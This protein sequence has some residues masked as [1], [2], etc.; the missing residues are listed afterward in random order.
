M[1]SPLVVPRQPRNVLLTNPYC[2]PLREMYDRMK[3]ARATSRNQVEQDFLETMPSFD[4]GLPVGLDPG[5]AGKVQS[6]HLSGAIQNGKGDWFNNVIALLLERCAGMVKE[7]A[8]KSIDLKGEAARRLAIFG[9]APTAGGSGG[10]DLS[11]WLHA[12]RP[13][14]Y[15]FMG[16]RVLGDTDFAAVVRWAETAAQVVDAVGLY[17]YEPLP[18]SYAEYRRRWGVPTVYEL[19]RVLFRACTELRGL[20]DAPPEPIPVD[21]P[22]SPA[23]EAARSRTR[24]R[25]R[26][27]NS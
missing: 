23:T 24:R 6:R 18:G 2:A 13:R 14:I 21:V 8:F 11:T 7:L 26:P 22:P 9:R 17:C 16:V 15:F 20:R 10:G 12:G 1:P 4:A 27:A 19:E 25:S 5:E 3:A